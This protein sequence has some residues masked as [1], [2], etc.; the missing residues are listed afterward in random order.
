MALALNLHDRLKSKL[1]AILWMF[2]SMTQQNEDTPAISGK[3]I[4]ILNNYQQ[5]QNYGLTK[6]EKEILIHICQGVADVT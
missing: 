4:R 1:T 6:R 2:K 3:I 5:H